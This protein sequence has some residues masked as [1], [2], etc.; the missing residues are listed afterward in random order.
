[1]SD[2]VLPL[3]DFLV[4][5]EH[6]SRVD[7][8]LSNLRAAQE[9]DPTVF[10]ATSEDFW[11]PEM[12]GLRPYNVDAGVLTI[13]VKGVL[14][15][16]FPFAFGGWATGYEYI[17]AAVERGVADPEVREIVLDVDS[18][19]GTVAGVFEA[20][21]NIYALR[22]K[23]PI[24]AYANDSAYS[25]AYAI[26]SA[27]DSINVTR[28]GGVG[29][30]GVIATHIEYSQALKKRG[31]KVNLIY[32]G[33][34]KADGHPSRPLSEKA[35]ASMQKRVDAFYDLFVSAVARNRGLEEQAVRDTEAAT[36]MSHEAVEEGLA[37]TVG[38][39]NTTS[40]AADSDD[41]KEFSM[42]DNTETVEQA[43]H[44]A[45]VAEATA[46]ATEAGKSAGLSEG[47]T[48]E[49]ERIGA[50]MDSEEAAKRP[51]AARHVALNSDMTVEAAAKFLAGLPEESTEAATT[52]SG[53]SFE[54]AMETGDN[55]NLGADGGEEMSFADGIFAS[56]GF[57]PVAQ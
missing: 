48:A 2:F 50:I 49:R 15:N 46:A 11:S 28:T 30:I 12:A 14:M 31:V 52:E 33:E 32:A 57:A 21:D 18:P 35:E 4:A 45:A 29:S 36:F 27:A 54:A 56:A 6:I 9:Q 10:M 38:P 37:D 13:P 25:A 7:M 22:G 47:A 39:L 51:A 41:E 34:R 19:G 8:S 43:A 23:K 53:T 17:E 24:R 26:A 1:M 55:P 3:S 42:S 16:K 40:A 44:E 5:E 20:T